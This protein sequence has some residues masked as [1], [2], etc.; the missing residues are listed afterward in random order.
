M[1]EAFFDE[2]LIKSE[3]LTNGKSH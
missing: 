3:K 2:T 1:F